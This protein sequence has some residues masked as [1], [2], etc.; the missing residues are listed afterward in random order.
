MAIIP[1]ERKSLLSSEARIQVPWIKV[2]IGTY[3]FGVFSSTEPA[4]KNANDFY[5]AFK[6][7]YPNYIQSLNIRK[8]NG[9]VNIYTLNIAYPVKVGDDPNFF[10]KVFS[11]VNK[12]RRIVFTYGD[13]S[14][15]SYI[16]KDEE[17]IITKVQQ[18]FGFGNGGTINS[19]INYTVEAVSNATLGMSGSFTFNAP[20]L[21]KPSDEIK[22]IFRNSNYGLQSLFTGMNES[23]LNELIDG[24][25]KAVKL[26]T[27]T[28][29]SPLDYISYLVGCMIPSG[30]IDGAI[31]KDIYILTIHDDTV[32]D[33]FYGNAS[34]GGPY[35][36][37]VKTSYAKSYSDAY[38]VDI[39]YNTSTIVTS[40]SVQN[41]E[42]F[43]IL[44]DYQAELHPENYIRRLNS[45][46]QYED[47]Y[48][49]TFTS[50]NHL[51][52]TRA[53]DISWYTKLTKYPI[54][55]SITIQ[56]LLRPATLMTYIR[57]N[58]IFPGGQK[59]NTSG[60]YIVT[61]QQD[62]ID[63]SGYRTTLGITRIDGDDFAT[64]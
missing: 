46:G 58:V 39:G 7:Q 47:E 37:V 60:L 45:K 30:T 15:P 54:S 29:I 38:E 61:E 5:S 22:R 12:T 57:I 43:S 42:Q 33:K 16:Y 35:F 23:N 64:T 1:K 49:P 10:D 41:N 3:T 24:T 31:S 20:G 17:A 56:G 53:E 34:L 59:H 19:V 36:K 4:K 11:S 13:A 8:I 44:Y 51:H 55:G 50:G 2:T 14:M 48:A 25:D 18:S 21:V 63:Q 28:N 40:F 6:V 52:K 9:Q 26:T 27:K 32:Y 62:R